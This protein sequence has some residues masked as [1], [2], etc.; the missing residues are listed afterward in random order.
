VRKGGQAVCDGVEG[1]GWGVGPQEEGGEIRG[2]G[3]GGVPRVGT[4]R[5]KDE[6]AVVPTD[7]DALMRQRQREQADRAPQSRERKTASRWHHG[8][9]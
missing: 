3:A 2:G 1:G 8:A 4:S 5:E 7:D 6:E 9:R